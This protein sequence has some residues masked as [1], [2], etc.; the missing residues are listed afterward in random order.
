MTLRVYNTM[1]GRK[2][3]F[4]P[5]SPPKVGMYACGVTVYDFCHIGHARAAVAFDVIARYLRYAG[6]DL[7]YVRNYTDVDDKIINRSNEQ[8]IPWEELARTFI[9]AHDVDM[10]SL[11]VQRADL[12]PRAT[13]YIGQ[14]IKTVEALVANG[15]A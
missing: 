13:D 6:Y 4:E 7:T 9:E 8:G 11:G 1:S 5:I 15:I 2:E 12:E 3:E 14:I 10:A